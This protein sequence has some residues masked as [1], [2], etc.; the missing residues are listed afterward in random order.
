MIHMS[1]SQQR[2]YAL[3]IW[4]ITSLVA[5]GIS[6]VSFVQ[7]DRQQYP[8]MPIILWSM[9]GI[10]ILAGICFICSTRKRFTLLS[11]P[12]PDKAW[13]GW[14]TILIGTVCLSGV[15]LGLPPSW[16]QPMAVLLRLYAVGLV[17]VGERLLLRTSRTGALVISSKTLLVLLAG[18]LLL[19]L[20]LVA[21][22]IGRVPWIEVFD[23]PMELSFS[24]ATFQIHS[25]WSTSTATQRQLVLYP[26]LLHPLNGLWMSLAGFGLI[27]ARLFFLAFGWASLIFIYL[28]ARRLYGY[29][30]ALAAVAVGAFIP[31]TYDFVRPDLL[32]PLATS[33]GLYFFFT[34]RQTRSYSRHY[35]AGLAV[36]LG[37]EGHPYAA[38]FAIAFALIYLYE[39]IRLILITRRWQWNAPFWFFALGGL[40]YSIFFVA[41]HMAI[42]P[43]G[44]N[45]HTFS[46]SYTYQVQYSDNPQ[47]LPL[48]RILVDNISY[49]QQYLKRHVSEA[50]VAV[51][52]VTAAARCH[53]QS[54]KLLL[55]IWGISLIVGAFSLTHVNPYYGIYNMPFIAIL[56]GALIA[57]RGTSVDSKQATLTG[58]AIICI[59]AALF[60]SETILTGNSPQ[61]ADPFIDVARQID[62][63]LPANITTI[64]GDRVYYLGILDHR[65]YVALDDLS[66]PYYRPMVPASTALILTAFEHRTDPFSEQVAKYAAANRL[67]RAYCF[68]AAGYQIT[69][70][71]ALPSLPPGAPIGCKE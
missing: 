28:T 20:A 60:S 42:A 13:F 22:Y 32:V 49:Y 24:W 35:L 41:V 8:A 39:Y 59:V 68:Y 57:R 34:A 55:S 16:D 12:L 53:K 48:Y 47:A 3:F 26:Y 61:A 56:A 54:D 30:A 65:R 31:L 46:E 29:Y 2:N 37:I 43:G 5:L 33:V 15:W 38:R 64:V 40:T 67:E 9:A 27:Q 63:V 36:A 1:Q 18:I 51:A 70:F 19:A 4:F 23:E 25:F 7:I 17:F 69:V 14:L 66:S 50:I 6:A 45:L 58:F 21:I 10:S 71:T 44:L 62:Q 11:V 52:A